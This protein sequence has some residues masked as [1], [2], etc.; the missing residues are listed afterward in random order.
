MA[1]PSK[2]AAALAPRLLQSLMRPSLDITASS[3]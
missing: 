1:S 3:E 2:A